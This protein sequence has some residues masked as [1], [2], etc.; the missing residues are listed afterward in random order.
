VALDLSGTRVVSGAED[1]TIR[2]WDLESGGEIRILN[3]TGSIRDIALHPTGRQILCVK[4]EAFRA[5][6]P[7][8][9]V[10]EFTLQEGDRLDLEAVA[11]SSDARYALTLGFDTIHIWDLQ[12]PGNQREIVRFGNRI[13]HFDPSPIDKLV[14]GSCLDGTVRIW[15]IGTGKEKTRLQAPKGKMSVG[16]FT[17]DGKRI[18]ASGENKQLHVWDIKTGELI[19]SLEGDKDTYPTVAMAITPDGRYAVCGSSTGTVQIRD[20][21]GKQPICTIL[22]HENRVEGVA[23]APDGKRLVT[24]SQDHTLRLWDLRRR[25]PAP[26]ANRSHL[27]RVMQIAMSPDG[28]RAVTGSGDQTLGVWNLETGER[29][30]ALTG[31]GAWI[32]GV[33]MFPDGRRVASVGSDGRLRIWD[34][35][36]RQVVRRLSLDENPY[37]ETHNAV[38]IT[39]D[40]R[41]V[42]ETYHADGGQDHAYGIIMWDPDTGKRLGLSVD[43]PGSDSIDT[44]AHGRGLALAP[45]G[46]FA[47]SA[48]SYTSRFSVWRLSDPKKGTPLDNGGSTINAITILSDNRRAVMGDSSGVVKIWDIPARTVLQRFKAHRGSIEDLALTSDESMVVTSSVDGTVKLWNIAVEECLASFTGDSGMTACAISPDGRT[49]VAGEES[50]AVHILRVENVLFPVAVARAGG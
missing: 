47:I 42:V 18:V 43:E 16:T 45:N 39:A 15:D 44:H 37:Y 29:E 14:A 24:A 19:R 36:S 5:W 40:G 35:D 2:V 3:E 48:H 30:G 12:N 11:Y 32:Q 26:D 8:R 49:V 13:W 6:D 46:E 25:A 33:A 7:D 31:T 23:I 4:R 17:P 22:A 28:R 50:G 41:R 21:R 27:G 1:G 10:V 20:L 9:A 38:A 34:I